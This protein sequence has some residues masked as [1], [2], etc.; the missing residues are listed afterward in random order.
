VQ[1]SQRLKTIT[2][3]VA[4][5]RR[6]VAELARLT[7]VS[8][9]TIRRDLDELADLGA[10]R[11]VRG[12]A[13]ASVQRGSSYPFALRADDRLDQK[14]AI[15]AAVSALVRPGDSL[16]LDNGT[17]A[18]AVARCLSGRGVTAMALSLHVAAALAERP[19]DEILV[20]GGP[21]DHDDL[22]FTGAGAVEAVQAMRYDLAFVS[23]CAADLATGLTVERWGDARVKQAALA[24]ARRVVLLATA[25]K[26]TRTAAHLFARLADLDTVV[27]S[28]DT[29][30]DIVQQLRLDGLEVIV[31]P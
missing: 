31:A 11:R 27:T 6:S 24:N 30:A 28:A 5:E 23:A 18:I 26:F 7:G 10:V 29:P 13:E 19:G 2:T 3:A 17:T 12:G 4:A 15:A 9:I 8:A 14:T 20:P 21:V 25:D 22:A 1:R 16:L